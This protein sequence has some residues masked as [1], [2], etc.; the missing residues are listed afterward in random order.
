MNDPLTSTLEAALR[1]GSALHVAS[2]QR[3]ITAALEILPAG[4]ELLPPTELAKRIRAAR[5]V[6]RGS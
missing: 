3:R 6:L 4:P 1:R 5:L 2:P